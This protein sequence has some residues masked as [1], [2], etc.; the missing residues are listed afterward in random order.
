[1][2]A[3]RDI[4]PKTSSKPNKKLEGVHKSTTEPAS[5]GVDPGVDY[6]SKDGETDK[7]IKLHSV[8]KHADRVGNGEDVYNGAKIAY[9][10]T[11][12]K[13]SRLAGQVKSGSKKSDEK[14]YESAECNHSKRGIPCPVHGKKECTKN[15]IDEANDFPD[16]TSKPKKEKNI[17]KP[18]QYPDGTSDPVRAKIAEA[19]GSKYSPAISKSKEGYQEWLGQKKKAFHNGPKDKDGKTETQ[20]WAEV[21]RKKREALDTSNDSGVPVTTGASSSPYED[22]K[23]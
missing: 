9:A 19:L 12:P 16:G 4:T 7:F 15:E 14:V 23:I 5:T 6:M 17:A 18:N 8:Q 22:G 13:N 1:M 3:L 11:D 2:K 21:K 20:K 10:L